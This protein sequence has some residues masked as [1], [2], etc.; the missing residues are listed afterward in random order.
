MGTEIQITAAYGGV[1]AG[2]LALPKTLPA[3]GLVVLPEVFNTNDHIRS[4]ADGYADE[5]FVVIAPDVYWRE[6]AGSYLPYTDEGRAKA[7]A[8]RAAMG[9][10]Q[11][12]SD[13]GDVVAALKARDD[14]T[15]KVGVVGF[16]LGGK[17]TYLSS[18]RHSIDAAVSYYGVQIDEHLD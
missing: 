9:T 17:F 18:V 13:L 11:F 8:L 14:C 16:C 10:D 1:F 5:G 3:P 4:V 2:Y 7:Q 6:E 15:G 12:A